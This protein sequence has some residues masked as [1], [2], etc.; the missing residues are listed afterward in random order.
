[1]EAILISQVEGL[2]NKRR[3]LKWERLANEYL[4]L[5]LQWK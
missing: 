2:L 5:E 1:L 4:N 3:E